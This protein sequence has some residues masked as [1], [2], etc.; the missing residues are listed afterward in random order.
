MKKWIAVL[1]FVIFSGAACRADGW[2]MD[3]GLVSNGTPTIN[4]ITAYAAGRCGPHQTFSSNCY[5]RFDDCKGSDHD[6]AM[7]LSVECVSQRYKLSLIWP[8]P[9]CRQHLVGPVAINVIINQNAAQ[10]FKLA[11]KSD[12][13]SIVEAALSGEQIHAFSQSRSIMMMAIG[14]AVVYTESRGTTA[15]FAWLAAACK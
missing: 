11:G 2:R 4:A 9:A 5:T 3:E 7:T 14:R 15:A 13:S 10:Q 12:E 1:C 6:C 8:C